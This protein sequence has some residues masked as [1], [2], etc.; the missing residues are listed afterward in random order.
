MDYKYIE[1]LLDRYFRAETTLQEEQILKSFFAQGEK[2]M[3]QEL[4]QYVPLFAALSEQPV[5]GDDFDERIIA[6][7]PTESS[8]AQPKQVK[9]RTIKLHDRLRPL[10]AA[11][12]M[13]A[14]ILT[15]GSAIS[16]SLRRD[17]TWMDVDEYASMRDNSREPAVAFDQVSDSLTRAKDDIPIAIT[18]DSLIKGNMD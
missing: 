15:V 10:F 8:P 4:K 11:A 7:L 6:M 1:Q 2:D 14:I 9:A 5:L 13:V 17:T 16:Q 18:P 3:P 12:A